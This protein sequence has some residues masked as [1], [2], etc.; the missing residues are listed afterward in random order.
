MWKICP[1]N[2]SDQSQDP[3][4]VSRCRYTEADQSIVVQVSEVLGQKKAAV[5]EGVQ[6]PAE[7]SHVE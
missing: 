3:L 7:E 4:P 2:V 1:L 6:V 5:T